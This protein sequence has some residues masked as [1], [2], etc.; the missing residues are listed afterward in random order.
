MPRSL[1]ET[2]VRL[3]GLYFLLSGVGDLVF[4]AVQMNAFD[5]TPVLAFLGGL[6]P[7]LV[8]FIILMLSRQLADF[9][10]CEEAG[11]A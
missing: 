10:H 3:L 11:R 6:G 5:D 9:A 2:L 4:G 8:G 1:T 7:M